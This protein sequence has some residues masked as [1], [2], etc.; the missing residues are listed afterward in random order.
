LL[1]DLYS[2]L[3]PAQFE[4]F[5]SRLLDE[6]GFSDVVVTGRSGDRGIDLEATWTQKNVPGLEVDLAFKI[7]AKR[8]SPST[9]NPRYVRELRGTLVSGEWGLLITTART[10]DNT[11]KEALSDASRVISVIDGN[12]LIDLCKEFGVGVKTNYQIDL[13]FLEEKDVT[14]E[15]PEI[16]E[17]TPLEMLTETLGEEFT[18]LGTSPIYKSET[19]TVIARTSKYYEQKYTDYWYGTKAIDLI[20][21]KKY[22]ITHF[23]FICATNGVVLIP[24]RIMLQEIEK[25]NLRKSTSKEGKLIHYHIYLFEDKGSMFWKLKTENKKIDELFFRLD[26]K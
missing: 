7:Q 8:Y 13:S 3:T 16:S 22:S 14:P 17:K 20:R 5:L 18:R 15:I 2:Q 19:K 10:S 26:E 11:R 25:N 24:K 21:V 4:I 23:A 6:M 1:E 9:I 12:G